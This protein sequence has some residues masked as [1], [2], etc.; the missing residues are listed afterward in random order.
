MKKT[1]K[2]IDKES[3]EYEYRFTD[4]I[5]DGF[6]SSGVE[7]HQEKKYKGKELTETWEENLI[8]AGFNCK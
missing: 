6:F 8:I 7:T 1:F 5:C 2:W 4:N 3:K